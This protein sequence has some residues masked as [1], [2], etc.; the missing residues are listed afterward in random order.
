MMI[1]LDIR[2]ISTFWCWAPHAASQPSRSYLYVPRRLTYF[3]YLTSFKM[4]FIFALILIL[5]W[6]TL[7]RGAIFALWLLTP[8][9]LPLQLT[10]SAALLAGFPPSPTASIW[11]HFSKR[12]YLKTLPVAVLAR[13]AVIG[14]HFENFS[15]RFFITVMFDVSFHIFIPGWSM[16]Q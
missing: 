13:T 11:R 10:S 15:S 14:G 4:L 8:S 1:L 9:Q 2:Y 12:S 16:P 5:P 6:Y 3:K 7:Y